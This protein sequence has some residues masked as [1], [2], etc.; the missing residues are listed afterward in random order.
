MQTAANFEQNNEQNPND[1]MNKNKQVMNNSNNG[2]APRSRSNQAHG[3]PTNFAGQ[4]KSQTSTL[5]NKHQ[6]A[7]MQINY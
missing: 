5:S 2:H 6:K 4:Q 7:A 1:H 3:Q